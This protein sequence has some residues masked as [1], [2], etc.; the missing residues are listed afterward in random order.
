MSPK[1]DLY[2]RKGSNVLKYTDD[3]GFSAMKDQIVNLVVAMNQGGPVW[4]LS[5]R[6]FEEGYHLI[7]MRDLANGNPG[8][9]IDGFCLRCGNS[10]QCLD[11]PIV[12]PGGLPKIR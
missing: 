7:E 5:R 2:A 11:L 4:W 10:G 1:D 8:I 12:K 9:D 6:I 3:L